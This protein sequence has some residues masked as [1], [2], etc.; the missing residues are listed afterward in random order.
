MHHQLSQS[1][2]CLVGLH[3]QLHAPEQAALEMQ[4]GIVTLQMI[5]ARQVCCRCFAHDI[6]SWGLH[7]V[8]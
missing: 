8:A 3:L 6:A 4:Q 1:A 2:W 5:M 7:V